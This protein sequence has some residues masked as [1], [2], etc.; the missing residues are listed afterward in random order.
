MKKKKK[1]VATDTE[2]NDTKAKSPNRPKKSFWNKA[3]GG[4][5]V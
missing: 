1:I 3:T 5:I 4:R 2:L